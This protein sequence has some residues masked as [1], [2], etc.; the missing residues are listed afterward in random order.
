MTGVQTCALPISAWK[1]LR[2]LGNYFEL[3]GFEYN[4]IDDVRK[5]MNIVTNNNDQPGNPLKQVKMPKKLGGK[6]FDLY[7]LAE[8]PIYRTDNIV[9]RASALQLTHDNPGA[10]ARVNSDQA[11]KLNIK[12][13]DVIRV[14]MLEGDAQVNVEIDERIPD[15]CIW[16]PAGYN[17]TSALGACGSASVS[18]L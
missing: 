2:V 10:N 7:R 4:S 1:I 13:G 12:Q 11:A 5:E 14:R 6:V 18:K 3:E 8:V 9:R 15:A 17:E 16:I